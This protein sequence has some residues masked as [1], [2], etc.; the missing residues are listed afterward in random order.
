MKPRSLFPIFPGLIAVVWAI[1]PGT[2]SAAEVTSTGTATVTDNL[3]IS[4][5]GSGAVALAHAGHVVPLAVS[6]TDFPGVARAA[7]DLQADFARVTGVTPSFATNTVPSSDT[8]I[9]IGTLGKSALIDGLVEAGKLKA[10]TIRGRWEAFQIEVVPHPLPGIERALVIAGSDKRG[11]I[12]GI[13]EISRQIGVSPWYW[14]ADVPVRRQSE[15]FVRPGKFVDRG[16]V[17]KYRG[18]F[19]NDEA[20]ALSGWTKEKFGGFNHKFYEKVFELILRLRGN[21]LW[22]AMWGSAF[23][24]DDPLNPKLADEYGIVMG[25]SHHEPLMR[26]HAEWA[27]YGHGPWD[28]SKNADVLREFWRG[29]VARTKD[30]ENIQ[31]IGMRG[32]GDEA[33]SAE[34]NTALLEQIVAD[35]RKILT[36][37]THKPAAEIPQLWALYKEVQAYYEHGMRVPD[38]VTLL[39]CDDNW[40]NIRRLPTT[41]ETKRSGGA[42]IY[43]HFDYVGGPRNYKWLNTIPLT[44]IQEQMN[45][46]WQYDAN[47]IWIVNVGDLKPME[48][49]IEFFLTMAWDPA[50]WSTDKL[51]AYSEKWAADNFGPAHASEIAALINGYTKLNGRRKPEMLAPDTFSLVNYHEAERVLAEWKTLTTRADTLNA[52]LAPEYRDAFFQLVLYPVKACANLQELYVAAGLNRLYARQ[53]RAATNAE[54]ARV[55]EAFAE[56]GR[57]VTQYHSLGGGKWDHMMDQIKLGYTI[58]QQPDIE[59][60]PA[61]AEVR[62]HHEASMAVAIEGS[63]IAWPSTGARS[64]A[65]P[66]LDSTTAETRW[67]DVFNRGASP[68]TF[69]A[70]ANQPWIKLTPANGPVDQTT[71]VQVGVDW[72]AAPEGETKATIS[73]EGSTGERAMIHLPLRKI[74]LPANT[75]GFV[76]SDRTIAI[77]AP[78]FNRTIDDGK[79]TWRVLPDFGRTLGG[80]TSFPVKAASVVPGGNSPHLEYDVFLTSSGEISVE[81]QCAPSLDFQ[82]GD[83]LQLAVSFDDAK[84]QIVKLDTWATLQTWEQAVGDGVRRVITQQSIAQ[85]GHH[86]FKFWL[87]TPGVVLERIV[88]N[89]G[90]VRPSYLGPPESPHTK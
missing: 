13:Y 7:R 85:P 82:P 6:D 25:T 54:A 20:P 70:T 22:P 53:G 1:F 9:L 90:G 28:Y 5:P 66:E 27:R 45:L 33:M 38:D 56:D 78:H 23:N 49:P 64:A 58:W 87:V 30:Y 77:E 16:P 41:A 52:A 68:F 3:I 8:V 42:G 73:I 48:F 47:R 62:P 89:A 18:I 72:A 79:N 36:E 50:R 44:K 69:H 11:T 80:V 21:Y 51:T 57:L 4:T 76:E 86:V 59:T 75:T 65:L 14:W 46:A 55:R 61:V 60:M 40:G 43:Y 2:L 12:Y 84:P 19:L 29:S 67:I 83:G 35:Q 26:A 81:L 88:L 71:R 15:L 17:V 10:D 63:E 32:D 34:T 24:D 37:V 39:W 31:T 74:V